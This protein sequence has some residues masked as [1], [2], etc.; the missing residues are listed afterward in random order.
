MKVSVCI[1]IALLLS[2]YAT[3]GSSQ[4]SDATQSK[5]LSLFFDEPSVVDDGSFI[6]ITMQGAPACVYQSGKPVLPM[7][8]STFELPFGSEIQ[9]VNIQFDAVKTMNL[10][11]KISPAPFPCIDGTVPQQSEVSLDDSVYGAT[12]LYPHQWLTYSTGGGLNTDSEHVTFFTMRVYPVRYN[13]GT[14]TI[15]YI[16]DCQIHINYRVPEKSLFPTDATNNLL[17]ISPLLFVPAL[18]KL[19]EHKNTLGIKTKIVS[20]SDIYG[21]YPGNDRPEQIKYYIKEAVEQ[22]G[23]TYVLLVGGL[24]S[25]FLGKPRDDRNVGTRDW[26]LPVRYTNLWDSDVVYD[27]GFISD[28]YYADIYDGNG[29]F[30]TWDSDGDGIYGRWISTAPLVNSDFVTDELDFYPDI[31]LGRLP[32]RNVVEVKTIVNKIIAYEKTAADP[33][34]FNRI[35]VIGGDPY[36]DRGT[37]Y[38]EGELIGHKVVI[39]DSLLGT[40]LKSSC[41][42]E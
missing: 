25:H 1:I 12:E 7:Y 15:E 40:I 8:T 38:I 23:S 22:W 11:K 32:C 3:V 10:Q 19:A 37:D 5:S 17:I 34:W 30:C 41:M 27:P 24:K 14:D 42:Q 28:L 13:P 9:T 31:Y 35:V 26:Y 29:E 20:L 6:D 36:D 2:T 33:S 4:S 18:E 39:S 21:N 16:D